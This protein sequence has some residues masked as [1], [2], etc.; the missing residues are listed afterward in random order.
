MIARYSRPAAK[1][2]LML[3]LAL[4]ALLAATLCAFFVGQYPLTPT[5]FGESFLRYFFTDQPLTDVDR[6]LWVLR[7]PRIL[8]ALIVGAALAVAGAT[9]QGMFRNPLVSPDILGVSAGAGLGA[10]IGI[11]LGLPIMGVQLFAFVGGLSAVL[12]VYSVSQW[13]RLQSPILSLVLAGVAI[14][15]LFGAGISLVK[16]LADPYRD[17][18]TMTFWML[19]SLNGVNM[20]DLSK[21]LPIL[22]ISLLPLVLLRWR[23]NLLSLDDDEAL[24]L[25]VNI[26]HLRLLF[27]IAAT[28]MTAATV[29]IT[30]MI[31]WIGLIIPHM[32]RLIVGPDFRRLLPTSLCMG[33]I[34]LLVADTL[35]RTLF[36]VEMPLRIITTLVGAPFF[37]ALLIRGEAR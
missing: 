19:G 2:R 11:Y 28:L 33:A 8:A 34:F 18:P 35:A 30:G 7:L 26:V 6:V 10:M 20:A 37:L 16:I 25:G 36:A 29:S 13:S 23:M 12:L 3:L 5:L 1:Y 24:A 21:A 17:L 4:C 27:I 9:Y 14:S 15:A 31:G 32:A 22:L